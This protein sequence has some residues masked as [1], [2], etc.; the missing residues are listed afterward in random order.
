MSQREIDENLHE[1]LEVD[2]PG[3]DLSMPTSRRA[4]FQASPS[5]SDRWEPT[6]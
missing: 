2:K 6:S 4:S 1:F 5:T 3:A